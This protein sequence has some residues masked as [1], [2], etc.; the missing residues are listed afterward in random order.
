MPY[1]ITITDDVDTM[2]IQY[3]SPPLVEDTIE[4]ATDVQTLDMNLYTDFYA[5]KRVWSNTL[6]FMSE[7][8]FNKLKGFYDRQFTL[9]KYPLISIT[10][11]GVSN[12]VVR[13]GLTPR[14]VVNNCGRVEE[15]SM[16]F[17]ETVQM[18]PEW[19]SS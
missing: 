19:G 4:G 3:P 16:T 17:R 14:R 18:T 2:T 7:S 13:M 8:D 1:E 15:V 10:D 6:S 11:L 12:V 5:T 9:W